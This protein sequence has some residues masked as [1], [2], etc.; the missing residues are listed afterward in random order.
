VYNI[1][2]RNPEGKNPLRVPIFSLEENIKTYL[3]KI[4]L[5]V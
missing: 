2:I 4:V 3:M 1:F 5:R